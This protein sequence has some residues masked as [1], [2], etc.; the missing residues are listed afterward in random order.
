LDDFWPLD[1]WLFFGWFFGLWMI[2][3]LWMHGPLAFVWFSG[4]WVF[5][6]PLDNS[7]SCTGW[8]IT[9]NGTND[10]FS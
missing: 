4:L 7:L 1:D 8:F 5:Y 3:V 2:F 6:C 9:V 10:Q